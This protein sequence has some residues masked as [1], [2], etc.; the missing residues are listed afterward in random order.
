MKIIELKAENVKRLKAVDITPEGNTVVISG[1]N[2]QGKT[3]IL[4][5]IWL[6]L[7]GGNAVKDSQTARPIREGAQKATVSLDLGDIKVTRS[8]TAGGGMTLKVENKEGAAYKSPQSLLDGM[9]GK[10]SFDP[11]AFSRMTPKEQKKTLISLVN[12]SIDPDELDNQR[13]ELYDRR[14]TVN[15]EAKALEGALSTRAPIPDGLPQEELSLAALIQNAKDASV[16]MSKNAELR[17]ILEEK[18]RAAAV[19]QKEIEEKKTLLASLVES[20]KGLAAQVENLKDPDIDAINMEI[21]NIE[22]TNAAIREA[23]KTLDFRVALEKTLKE[24]DSLSDEIKALDER[25]SAALQEAKF[26]IDG[27]GFD[28]EGVLFRGIPF[29]QCSS[30]ERMKVSLAIASSLNP[31]IRVIRVNDGSLLDTQSMAEVEAIAK[32]HD[33]QVWIERVDESGKVGIVIEDGEILT[34]AAAEMD[35]K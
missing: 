5:A 1:R 33:M 17:R 6:A 18:R 25:K 4:D 34:S 14:T 27:L 32:E 15:R 12:L 16:E 11:L 7:A 24:S 26:P 13:R 2:G 22:N 29:A 30:A 3:S 21:S 31:Q 20:G 9:I 28:D 19:L 10:L 35:A 8:W 23:R